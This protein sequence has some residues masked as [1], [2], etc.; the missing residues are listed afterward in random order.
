[1]GRLTQFDEAEAF[2][3]TGV[4]DVVQAGEDFEISA[5]CKLLEMVLA[6]G[7]VAEQWFDGLPIAD[8]IMAGNSGAAGIGQALAD[9][10]AEGT[11]LAGAVGTEQT[12]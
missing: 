4:R 8:D 1:M 3:D 6:V 11:A 10:D 9:E 2:V 5:T 12:K 7:N